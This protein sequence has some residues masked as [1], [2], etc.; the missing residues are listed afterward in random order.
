VRDLLFLCYG[1]DS[2]HPATLATVN[3]GVGYAPNGALQAMS[4]PNGLTQTTVIEPRLDPCRIDW[5]S[6]NT[7]LSG[8]GDPLPSG[9][10]QD[11][12]YVYGT[13]GSS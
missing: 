1:S 2:Q 6:S 3:A 13:W 10:V 8:C 5:N 7:L 12:E 11:F 4:L 9:M